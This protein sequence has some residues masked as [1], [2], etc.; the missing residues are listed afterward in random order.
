MKRAQ[1]LLVGLPLLAA[2]AAPAFAASPV[3]PM[4]RPRPDHTPQ[5]A[6]PGPV[7][8]QDGSDDLSD[9]EA[10]AATDLGTTPQRVTLT[11]ELTEKSARISDGLVWRIYDPRPDKNGQIALVA[12]SEQASPTLILKPG[13]YV[14]HVAY[15]RAQASDTL[16]VG[17]K[18]TTKDIVLDVGALKLNALIVG[19]LPIPFNLLHFSIYT[20]GATD[21]EGTLVADK[22]S[23]NDI[24][25]LNA[26]T[27]HV[28]A[29][30]GDVNAVVRAD[31]RVE[32]GQL[33]EATLYEKGAQ[34][35]FK[36]VSEAG[37]EAIADIDWT[38][39]ASDG[40][41]VFT[42]TGTFPATVLEAGTYT[43]TAKRGGHTYTKQFEVKPGPAQDIEVVTTAG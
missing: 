14:V 11:A 32:P 15:G 10:A 31:L 42:N 23:P 21:A 18:A 16:S 33:T 27:Y 17:S 37:G 7:L 8:V 34:V 26:G 3:V 36:L 39:Q 20:A 6:T 22:V 2:I 40:S 30:F 19:D 24:L 38:V 4:P 1:V 12:K 43:V 29:Y 41:S 5:P 28:A 35:S 13:D 9:S 25:T